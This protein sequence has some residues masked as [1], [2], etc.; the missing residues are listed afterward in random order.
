MKQVAAILLTIIILTQS[1]SKEIIVMQFNLNRS[2]IAANLCVK[3]D[4][5]ENTCQG[6]CQLKKEM[7]KEN[8]KEQNTD[9]GKNANVFQLFCNDIN[10][11]L[12]QNNEVVATTICNNYSDSPYT[13]PSLRG[14]FHPPKA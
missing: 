13:H 7:E 9:T 2:Y 10:L 4:I 3:K 8:S 12:N 14:I 5:A 6:S 11:V 1:F